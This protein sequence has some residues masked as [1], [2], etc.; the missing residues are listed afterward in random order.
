MYSRCGAAKFCFIL[1]SGMRLESVSFAR[2]SLLLTQKRIDSLP[3]KR[4]PLWSRCV[5]RGIAG[6]G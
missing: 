3:G 2:F 5:Y 6:N 1:T 4:V